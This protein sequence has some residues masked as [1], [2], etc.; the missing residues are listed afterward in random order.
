MDKFAEIL[1]ELRMEKGMTQGDL[2][3]ALNT[4]KQAI[5]NYEHGTRYPKKDMLEAIADLF[6]VDLDFL[7]GRKPETMNFLSNEEH[8]IITAYR[9]ASNDTKKA[10][11]NVLCIN[12]YTSQLF[13]PI[14]AHERTD[15][16]PTEEGRLNDEMIM[17]KFCEEQSN[18][19]KEK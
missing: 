16:R 11:K 5:S 4:S 19:K 12:S 9:S 7:T 6:N 2:A 3:I 18:G 13:Q 17:R 14:A 10:V 15:I 8:H 1:K